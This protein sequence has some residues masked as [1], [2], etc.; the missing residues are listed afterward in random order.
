MK[1][2][3]Y[4]KDGNNIYKDKKGYY[5]IHLNVNKKYLPISWNPTYGNIFNTNTNKN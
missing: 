2:Y 5:I 4:W 3:G 1:V